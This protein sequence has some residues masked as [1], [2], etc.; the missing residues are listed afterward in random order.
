MFR[1]QCRHLADAPRLHVL[2][3]IDGLIAFCSCRAR[4]VIH[5]TR[6]GP[7]VAIVGI[8]PSGNP[9]EWIAHEFEHLLEQLDGLRLADLAFHTKGV[10]R[11]SDQ[12][13]ETERAIRAGRAVL[14]DMRANRRRGNNFVE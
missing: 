6:E 12:M 7:I 11:T 13:F 1:D 9:I 2:V 10:W 5:R 14:E 4:S 8:S 3:R